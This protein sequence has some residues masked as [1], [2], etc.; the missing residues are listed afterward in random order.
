MGKKIITILCLK[1]LQIL[2]NALYI[3]VLVEYCGML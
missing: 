1:N 2:A 3:Q